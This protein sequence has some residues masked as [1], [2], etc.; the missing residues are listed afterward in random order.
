MA[1]VPIQSAFRLDRRVP[2]LIGWIPKACAE[3]GEY[4]SA[5]QLAQMLPDRLRGPALEA[6]NEIEAKAE[7]RDQGAP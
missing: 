7:R 1:A 2:K 4:E 6:V 3:L 5:K